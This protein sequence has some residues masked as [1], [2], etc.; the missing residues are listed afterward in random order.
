MESLAVTSDAT[1]SQLPNTAR[2]TA[3]HKKQDTPP[4]NQVALAQPM[5][6]LPAVYTYANNRLILAQSINQHSLVTFL[7]LALSCQRS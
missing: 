5:P 3:L 4:H 2:V 7:S 1:T 6:A